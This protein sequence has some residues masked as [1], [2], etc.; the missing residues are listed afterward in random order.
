MNNLGKVAAAVFVSVIALMAQPA[1]ASKNGENATA[2]VVAAAGAAS[3]QRKAEKKYCAMTEATTG[4]RLGK[5]VCLTERQWKDE[6]VDITA[7][8]K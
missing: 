5:K 8:G 7:Q 3:A 4:T 6:G 2:A 1:V